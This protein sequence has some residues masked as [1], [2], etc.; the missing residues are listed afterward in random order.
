MKSSTQS[1]NN[2]TIYRRRRT[3]GQGMVEY[4]VILAFGVMMLMGPG[5][6]V[7]KDLLAVVQNK[8]RGYSYSMSMSPLPDFDTGP[9]LETYIIGLNLDPAIDDETLARLTVDPVQENVTAALQ[10]FASAASAFNDISD[11]LNDLPDLGDLASEM[12]QDAI[13]PF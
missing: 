3:Y 2:K 12:L 1:H 9:Q 7:I 8:Y 10:P 6:D 13:S 5:G 4:V 11:L